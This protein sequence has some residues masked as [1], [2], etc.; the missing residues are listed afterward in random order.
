MS[1]DT[2]AFVGSGFPGGYAGFVAYWFAIVISILA[3]TALSFLWTYG[4]AELILVL[5][6]IEKN[7]R[8]K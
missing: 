8:K 4:A 7:T 6:T 3:G 1:A 5:L 2:R